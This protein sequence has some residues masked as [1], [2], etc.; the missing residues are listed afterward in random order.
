MK[1]R[2]R[3]IWKTLWKCCQNQLLCHKHKHFYHLFICTLCLSSLFVFSFFLH[4]TIFRYSA[5]AITVLRIINKYKIRF[6]DKKAAAG[7]FHTSN[8]L[9]ELMNY[10][11]PR[12]LH[13]EK[14]KKCKNSSK[15]ET[16]F[17]QTQNIVLMSRLFGSNCFT[18]LHWK[19]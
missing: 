16:R 11:R 3:W 15:A 5:T 9:K 2:R 18:S 1:C 6:V 12:T 14:W 7:N 13:W 8:Y 19:N 17:V 4:R 10:W